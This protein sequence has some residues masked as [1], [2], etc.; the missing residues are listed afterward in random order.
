MTPKQQVQLHENLALRDN[1]VCIMNVAP[2]SLDSE[3]VGRMI[4]IF[5]SVTT[6]SSSPEMAS[7]EVL[8]C[9][10]W[11]RLFLWSLANLIKVQQ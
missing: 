9:S 2:Q 10:M 4:S 7:P 3:L 5:L 1:N 8:I 11:G 6:Q